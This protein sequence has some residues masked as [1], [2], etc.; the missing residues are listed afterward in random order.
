MERDE[1]A[2]MGRDWSSES[3]LALTYDNLCKASRAMKIAQEEPLTIEEFGS[4]IVID[5]CQDIERGKFH[6]SLGGINLNTG[7]PI[8]RVQCHPADL[9]EAKE[10]V[11]GQLFQAHRERYGIYGEQA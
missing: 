5:A 3:G 9:I 7:M 11:I 6:C 10:A 1:E 2:E 4:H 8:L